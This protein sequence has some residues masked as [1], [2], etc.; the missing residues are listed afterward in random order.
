MTKWL[1]I[2]VTMALVSAPGSAQ[3]PAAAAFDRLKGLVGEWETKGPDGE[4]VIVSYELASGGT[5]VIERV[6]GVA[7]HG[8]SGMTSLF[9][10]SAG[11]LAVAHFCTAGNQPRFVADPTGG[12]TLRFALVPGSINDPNEGHIHEIQVRFRSGGVVETEWVWF[13]RGRRDHTLIRVQRRR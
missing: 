11:R 6:V 9:H 1:R 7:E 4:S 3:T 10:L 13:D 12:D 5:A 8:P 2:L